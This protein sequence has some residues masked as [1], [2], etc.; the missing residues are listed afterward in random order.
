MAEQLGGTVV[1]GGDDS[2][3][4]DNDNGVHLHF[5]IEPKIVGSRQRPTENLDDRTLSDRERVP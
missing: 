2:L 5:T 3:G 1:P 4:I